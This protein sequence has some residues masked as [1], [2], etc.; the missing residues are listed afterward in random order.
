[1]ISAVN[2]KTMTTHI[3]NKEQCFE[4]IHKEITTSIAEDQD[5]LPRRDVEKSSWRSIYA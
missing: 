5:E 1:M 4:L 2:G 3:N